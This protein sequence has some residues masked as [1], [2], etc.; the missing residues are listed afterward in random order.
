MQYLLL[1]KKRPLLLCGPISQSSTTTASTTMA[2]RLIVCLLSA[3]VV[4]QAIFIFSRGVWDMAV[5][6]GFHCIK[7]KNRTCLLLNEWDVSDGTFSW[8]FK[9]YFYQV[10]WITVILSIKCPNFSKHSG[11]IGQPTYTGHIVL[12]VH[13]CSPHHIIPGKTRGCS[14]PRGNST[15]YKTKGVR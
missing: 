12:A 2:D 1:W 11:Y 10:Q 9:E 3:G 15:Q 13:Q 5:L 7:K 8:L 4:W 6:I 14:R